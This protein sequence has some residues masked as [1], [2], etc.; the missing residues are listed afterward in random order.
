MS[1]SNTA[2]LTF[3]FRGWC[4]EYYLVSHFCSHFIK[5]TCGHIDQKLALNFYPQRPIMATVNI[6]W[7]RLVE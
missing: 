2:S 3:N 1:M 7:N 6:L 5:V 4:P